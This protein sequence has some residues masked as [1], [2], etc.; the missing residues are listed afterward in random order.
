MINDFYPSVVAAVAV[1]TGTTT[2]GRIPGRAAREFRQREATTTRVINV[3][4]IVL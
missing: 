1:L 2:A 3:I 4:L